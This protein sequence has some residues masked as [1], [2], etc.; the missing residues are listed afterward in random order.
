MS[1]TPQFSFK[2][3]DRL[4]TS[5]QTLVEI[6]SS[7]D[8]Q[9]TTI[10]PPEGDLR[11]RLDHPDKADED[12]L[13]KIDSPLDGVDLTA[14]TYSHPSGTTTHC[15]TGCWLEFRNIVIPKDKS[16]QFSYRFFRFGNPHNGHNAI[17]LLLTYP[18]GNTENNPAEKILVCD[19]VH[20]KNQ[21]DAADSGW[22]KKSVI[23]YYPQSG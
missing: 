8:Q 15:G 20:L 19:N 11:A 21:N 9:G 10:N 12:G 5:S 23:M 18:G 2:G 7:F 1:N 6:D 4:K 13:R 3:N 22:Q 17:A 16:L 14:L